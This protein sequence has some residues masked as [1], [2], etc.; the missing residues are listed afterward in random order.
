[1]RFLEDLFYNLLRSLGFLLLLVTVPALLFGPVF[2]VALVTQDPLLSL[3]FVAVWLVPCLAI[4]L[5]L[6]NSYL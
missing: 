2:A 3:V 1:M 4:V 6:A 5:T